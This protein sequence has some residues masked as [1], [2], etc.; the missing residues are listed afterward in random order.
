M[1]SVIS[2]CDVTVIREPVSGA[3][4]RLPSAGFLAVKLRFG[5]DSAAERGTAKSQHEITDRKITDPSH[6]Q[7]TDESQKYYIHE[8]YRLPELAMST[9]HIPAC[10]ASNLSRCVAGAAPVSFSAMTCAS[11]LAW[12]IPQ[13]RLYISLVNIIRCQLGPWLVRMSQHAI[14][15][16]VT[17][18]GFQCRCCE[19]SFA[20]LRLN[21]R[22]ASESSARSVD[23][24]RLAACL[25]PHTRLGLNATTASPRK[26]NPCTE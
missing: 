19:F 17:T 26:S 15:C 23:M 16:S 22:G 18:E 25:V 14:A 20:D 3:G 6:S 13:H 8:C 21:S 2:S 11:T 9:L 5:C 1:P 4:A 10:F 12:H 24:R 7:I